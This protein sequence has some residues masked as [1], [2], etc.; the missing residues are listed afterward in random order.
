MGATHLTGPLYVGGAAVLPSGI[1][2]VRGNTY[3][4]DP[5]AAAE[6]DGSADSPFKTLPV[7]YAACVDGQG[8]KI[9]IVSNGVAS[10][11]SG[12][13]VLAAAFDWAKKNTHLIGDCAPT[14]IG[15][16]VRIVGPTA[17]LANLF[18]VSGSG[19]V[20]ANLTIHDSYTVDP[21]A[22]TVT[23]SR[24]YFWNCN[25]QGMAAA[26]G[27]D[28]AAGASVKIDAGQENTFEQCVIGLD[29]VARST[30][31]AELEL[32][33]AAA[34][35]VFKDCTFLSFCDN[36]GHVF[37]KID[38]AAD[39]DRFVLF[40]NCMFYN[41]VDSTSTTMTNAMVVQ[42]DCGGSVIL[43]NCSMYGATD[44]NSADVGNVVTNSLTAGGG[45]T[46]SM[47]LAVTR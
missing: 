34:R 3:Y 23:G 7:A 12:A 11:A 25:I 35:N 37:V 45:T 24:N 1:L 21:V 14:M 38:A 29:T 17:G 20:F 13:V 6:G 10:T 2:G 40:D 44:W 43:K 5:T 36:A 31:N 39:I 33:N 42:T 4:L 46:T 41:A 16:R 22:L 26:T 47:L 30:T 27:G 15:Q 8:D 28:D 32:V 19:C 9:I 18:K